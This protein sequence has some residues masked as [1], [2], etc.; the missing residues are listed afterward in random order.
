M[1][2]GKKP[3]APEVALAAAGNKARPSVVDVHTIDP[4]IEQR[5]KELRDRA[6]AHLSQQEVEEKMR[7]SVGAV[8]WSFTSFARS[9]S[10]S[11]PFP[12]WTLQ[13]TSTRPRTR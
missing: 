6:K 1:S 3:S 12:V 11:K 4:R 7:E 5:L 2:S 13:S 8:F 9:R 10:F